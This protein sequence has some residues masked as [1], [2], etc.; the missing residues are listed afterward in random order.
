MCS[1]RDVRFAQYGFVLFLYPSRSR[2]GF[3]NASTQNVASN[4]QKPNKSIAIK[5]RRAT[6][7][8]IWNALTFQHGKGNASTTFKKEETHRT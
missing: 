6:V 4:V 5:S 1:V 3:L 2:I 8:L 7:Q